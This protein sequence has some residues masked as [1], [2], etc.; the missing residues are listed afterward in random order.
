MRGLRTKQRL[1][2]ENNMHKD[3]AYVCNFCGKNKSQVKKMIANDVDDQKP[4]I[5]NEC[6]EVCM[7]IIVEENLELSAFHLL[8]KDVVA[9]MGFHP[10]FGN[11][12]TAT[13]KDSCFYLGPF[14]D[15]FNTIYAD[16]I[17]PVFNKLNYVITR[18]DEIFSTDV[19]VEDIWV[20]INS[21][22][23]I[24]AEVTGKN[25]NVLY[26]MGMA[27][28]IGKPVLMVSQSV[29][30]IPFDLRHRRCVVYS[31]TP[32]G[33]RKLE[34]G[35]SQTVEYLNAARKRPRS[36]GFGH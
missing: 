23:L 35:I 19:I 22:S 7:E 12:T 5:C 9:V 8:P 31:Y 33:C 24:V 2:R 16:H 17:A 11:R 1:G 29:D 10:I 14:A 15:P 34:E 3:G 26:E 4:A 18:A 30:D 13:E 36:R 20:A 27:H 21:A 28:T 25:P 6:L 32:Q